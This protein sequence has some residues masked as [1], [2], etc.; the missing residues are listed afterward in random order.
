M[1]YLQN[2]LASIVDHKNKKEREEFES[3]ATTLFQSPED[4]IEGNEEAILVDTSEH[5]MA[6]TELFDQLVAFFPEHMSQPKGNLVDL[7]PL[8]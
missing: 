6:R 3:L 4:E 2:D 8:T 1:L 7:I 5:H